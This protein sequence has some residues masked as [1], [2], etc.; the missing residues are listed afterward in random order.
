MSAF[1]W[2][3]VREFDLESSTLWG[4]P[5]VSPFDWES[6]RAFSTLW[7]FPFLSA[8]EWESV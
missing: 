5:S 4:F 8:F 2:E 7:G 1:D 3:S 6:S